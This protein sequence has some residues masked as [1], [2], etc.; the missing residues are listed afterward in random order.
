MSGEVINHEYQGYK[1]FLKYHFNS[2]IKNKWKR[3]E[4]IPAKL[5]T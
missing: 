3:I 1:N 4:I 2:K 5:Y